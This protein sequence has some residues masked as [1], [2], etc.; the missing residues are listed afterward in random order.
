[1]AARLLEEKRKR[2]QEPAADLPGE[3]RVPESA[4]GHDLVL[5]SE[6]L[7]DGMQLAAVEP[8]AMQLAD[9]DFGADDRSNLHGRSANGTCP[10]GA[11]ARLF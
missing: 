1:M 5:F 11:G 4:L 7:D 6:A 3:A 10:A 8:D 9:I 2:S